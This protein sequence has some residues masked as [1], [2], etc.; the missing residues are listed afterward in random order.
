[1][2]ELVFEVTTS[3]KKDSCTR[4]LIYKIKNSFGF[5]MRRQRK[6]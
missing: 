1:M 4:I 3:F 6:H 5:A 2:N